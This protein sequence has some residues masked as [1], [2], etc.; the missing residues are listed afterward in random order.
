MRIKYRHVC[1]HWLDAQSSTDWK[2]IEDI[3][4]QKLALCISTGYVVDENEES[5]TL[6]SDFA[7]GDRLEIDSFG[8]CITIPLSCIV[9]IIDDKNN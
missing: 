9:K 3:D 5:I 6:A 4:K 7:S 8:N 2:T 1:V